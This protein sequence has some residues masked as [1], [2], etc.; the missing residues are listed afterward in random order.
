MILVLAGTLDGRELAVRLAET[1]YQVIV[2]V[3]SDYGRSLAE[4]P[5][6]SVHAGQL[7]V[8]GMKELIGVHEIKTIVDASHPYAVNGSVNAMAACEATGIK[9]IRYERSVVSV[10]AE[11]ERLYIASDAGEAAKIAAGLGKVI[12]LT[13]GSRTLKLFKN[14][15]LLAEIRIIARVLPQPDVIIECI[16]LGFSPGDIV[17]MQGP[18]SHGLNMAM[19]KEYGTEVVITK[20]SGII[21]GAD[22]KISAAMELGLPIIVIGRPAIE[23]KNLCMTQQ[24]VINMVHIK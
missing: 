21:G 1:G 3:I 17:A 20:N 15:P 23:Y 2:S 22:T 11:Y 4:F 12:F 8:E 5:G 24:E 14:E 16:E 7:T 13:T 18:F 10:P 9:Y 6:I 19:F